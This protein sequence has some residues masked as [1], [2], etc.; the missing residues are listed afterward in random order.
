MIFYFP[1]SKHISSRFFLYKRSDHAVGLHSERNMTEKENDFTV[2]QIAYTK[3]RT[4]L[5]YLASALSYWLLVLRWFPEDDPQT[6]KPPSTS[7]EKAVDTVRC[8]ISLDARYPVEEL[9]MF[10]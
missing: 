5:G 9:A 4:W 3:I 6:G 10:S 1:R 7:N 8:L 2:E